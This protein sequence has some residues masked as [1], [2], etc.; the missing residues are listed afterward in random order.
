MRRGSAKQGQKANRGS[1]VRTLMLVIA[2]SVTLGWLAA[3]LSH[4]KKKPTL[5][6]YKADDT[7]SVRLSRPEDQQVPSTSSIHYGTRREGSGLVSSLSVQQGESVRSGGHADAEQDQTPAS[8]SG[9]SASSTDNCPPGR[10]PY[11][12]LLTAQ[13]SPYQNWQSRIM[14]YHWKKQQ[15]SNPCTEMTNFTRLTATRD[16]KPDGLENEIPSIFMKQMDPAELARKYGSF[17]VL[18]RPHTMVM[19]V[20][21]P[22][23]MARFQEEYIFIAETDHV[24]FKDIPNFATETMPAGYKFGYMQR[25][26]GFDR[27]IKRVWPEGAWDKHDQTGPSPLIIHKSQLMQVAQPWLDFSLAL[28]IDQEANAA[29]GWVLEMWGYV[30]AAGSLGIKHTVLDKFQIE[31]ANLN[32][33][34]PNFWK[35]YYIFHYTYGIEYTMHGEPMLNTIGEWSLD[36]RHYG[37][38]YPPR[39]LQPPPNEGTA[40]NNAAAFWL[41][42]AFNEATAAIPDWP[43]Y[44]TLGTVGWRREKITDDEY[45]ASPIAKEISNGKRWSWAGSKHMEFK[46]RGELVTPWGGGTWGVRHDDFNCP[47]NLKD[48]C[49]YADFANSNHNLV[50]QDAFSFVSKRLG[51]GEIVKGQL[52]G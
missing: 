8:Q 10:K 9:A 12:V 36:K 28:K 22:E 33:L 44:P 38:S 15:K 25:N 18:N 34:G 47:D 27:L 21:D 37:S 50:F 32:Q 26:R 30:L 45:N 20:N 31:P 40:K 46:P 52:T 29:L 35:D 23:L 11:H 14:Y 16:G 24:L 49:V 7:G 39:N 13:S 1:T 41:V 17:G 51:D 43:D 4:L 5:Q 48:R 6:V 2:S 42:N 19:L 3:A